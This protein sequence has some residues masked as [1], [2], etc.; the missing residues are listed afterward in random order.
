MNIKF[1]NKKQME[2]GRIRTRIKRK[3]K[4]IASEYKNNKKVFLHHLWGFRLPKR[5]ILGLFMHRNKDVRIDVETVWKIYPYEHLFVS[6]V[7]K[8][9]A[10][11]CFHCEFK[12]NKEKYGF[13][14]DGEHWAIRKM[15]Y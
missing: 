11:E 7:T 9:I 6:R 4:M 2:N 8:V 12:K 14:V 10:H 15:G 3:I 13:N 5:D 1:L